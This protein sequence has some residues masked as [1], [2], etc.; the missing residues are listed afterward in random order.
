M[1]DYL[2]IATRT[3]V[4][5]IFFGFGIIFLIALML[6]AIGRRLRNILA[7]KLGDFYDYLV[8]PGCLCHELGRTIGCWLSGTG[9][10]KFEI[11]NLKT[12]DCRRIPIAVNVNTRF[13]FLKRFLILTGPVWFGC[14]IVCVMTTLA[15]GTEILPS[16]TQSFEGETDVG[17]ISYATAL[18]T[19][20]I[21]MLTSFVFVW[22]WTSP[23]C[24]IAFYF[25]FCIA[26]QITISGRAMLLIWQSVIAVFLLLFLLNLIPGVNTGLAWIGDRIKP[27]VFMLHVTM[28]FVVFI[29]LI[30]LV[31]AR[32]F[33]GKGRSEGRR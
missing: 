12:D 28:L 14:A 16:Y 31:I 19:Q 20:G 4:R 17:L 32:I 11:F 25:L 18:V 29:D 15:A 9:V 24:L 22:H 7:S 5:Q 26:S 23:F 13:A 1:L 33:F 6:N 27:A 2:D 30:F 21:A 3:T 10:G 8:L